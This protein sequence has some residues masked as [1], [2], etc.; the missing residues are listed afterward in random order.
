ML[1]DPDVEKQTIDYYIISGDNQSQFQIGKTGELFVSKPLDREQISFYNLVILATDGKFTAEANVE[2]HIKDINDNMPFCV[3][4]RYHITINE[5]TPIGTIIV[6]VKA[7]DFDSSN[8][9]KLRFYISGK[10]SDDFVIGKESGILKVAKLI[11]REQTPKYK[12]LAHVQD[13]KEFIRE[14]T[15]EIIIT[16]N[17]INDNT[18]IFSIPNYIVSIQEDAQLQTLVAKVHAT[19][20]DFGM[21]R[22]IKYSLIG[23]NSDYFGISKSTGIIKLDK[24]LDRET[25]SLYNLTVMAEDFGNPMLSSV[26][27]FVINILDINDNPPEFS[28]RKYTSHVYE[29]ATEGFEICKIHATSKDIGV[30]AEILYYIVSGNEQRKFSI[31]SSTGVLWVNGTLDYEK[32]KFYFLTVQAIDGGSPPL[33]NIANVNIS[34]YDVNDNTPTFI[35]NI[36]RVNVKEDFSVDFPIIDVKATDEDSNVNGVVRYNIANGDNLHQFGVNEGNGTITLVRPLDRETISEYTLEIQ[37]CD[38]GIPERCSTVQVIIF[39]L[40]AND[41][42]PIFLRQTTALFYKKIDH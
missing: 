14:C 15:S 33:S 11:D 20:K 23:T 29:N 13:G 40:D 38:F 7:M 4:P 42:P 3:K 37:A 35:Q 32:T 19:D 9:F 24:R 18:P 26:A 8:D 2:V 10:G 39:I 6:K 31:N 1:L 5:S 12:I 36:Y 27:N 34:I 21:N 41:N 16:I 30:N 17:D 28:L 25:I 22:K